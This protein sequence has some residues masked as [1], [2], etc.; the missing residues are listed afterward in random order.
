M[1]FCQTKNKQTKLLCPSSESKAGGALARLIHRLLCNP[2]R[3]VLTSVANGFGQILAKVPKHNSNKT[4]S[5]MLNARK[6][7]SHKLPCICGK[8]SQLL[9]S[10]QIRLPKRCIFCTKST[11]EYMGLDRCYSI[12]YQKTDGAGFKLR[13]KKLLYITQKAVKTKGQKRYFTN[14]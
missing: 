11:T 14:I 12:S 10:T 8:G 6:L 4:T 13:K 2:K 3:S 9:C 5:M 1:G 7:S